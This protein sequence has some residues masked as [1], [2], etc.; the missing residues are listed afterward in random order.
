MNQIK[1]SNLKYVRELMMRNAEEQEH[2]RPP[3]VYE[4]GDLYRDS[5]TMVLPPS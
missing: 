4:S 2:K 1:Q 5:C 3:Y